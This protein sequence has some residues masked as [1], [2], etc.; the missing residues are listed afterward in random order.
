MSNVH[1]F[2]TAPPVGA[3]QANA[4]IPQPVKP[5][6]L[7]QGLD[8]ATPVLFLPV[9]IETRFMDSAGRSELWVRIYPDQIAINSH[10]PE[11]TSQEIT[12]GQNYWD[13]VWRAGKPPP[14]LDAVKAPW[15]GLASIYGAQ[16]A[17]WIAL[18]M[19]PTN[20]A[21][22]PAAPTPD[23]DNPNPAPAYPPSPATL[24]PSSWTKPAIA[25]ALPDAWTVVTVSGTQTT[26]FKGSPITPDLA[27][28][29]TPGGGQFAP[30]SPVDPGMTWLVDF[31]AALAAGMALK[32]P[33]NPEQRRSGFDRIFVYGLRTSG[34]SGSDAFASLLDAHHYTDGFS[35]VPQGAPTNNTPDAS[36]AYSRKDADYE[37][38]F[39]VERQDALTK[40]ADGDG[41]AFAKG[42]GI[43]PAHMDH[44]G[45]ADGDG[46]CN[47][48]DMLTALWPATLGYFFKQM[49]ADVFTPADIEEIRDFVLANAI[50]RG[51]IPAFR[52]GRTPYGIV[53][54][55]SFSRYQP[56]SVF[57][58][59]SIEPS[60]VNFVRALWPSWLASSGAAPHMQNTGD[61]DKELASVLGMDAS[62]MTFRGRKILGD[63][64]LWNY[65]IFI[66]IPFAS[67]SLWWN[68]HLARGRQLL[69]S[70]GLNRWDPRVIHLGM[71]GDSYPVWFSTVQSGPLSETDPLKADASLSGGT[72]GNYIQWLRQASIGEI[73]SENY[74]GPKPTSLLYKIL[75]QSVILE[76]ARLATFAEVDAGRLQLSQVREAELIAIQPPPALPPVSAWEILARPSIPNPQLNWADYLVLLNPLPSSPFARLAELRASLDRLA[77][78]PTAELDRLLTES[79][80]ACS[81]RLDVWATAVANAMLKRTRDDKVAGVH[82]GAF[83]WV[84]EVRPAAQR[85]PIQ[86]PE[87]ERVRAL[88][89]SRAQSLKTSAALATPVEPLTDNGGFIYAPSLAQASTA[90]VLRNGYMTHKGTADEGILSIDLSS[91]RVR[92]ALMLLDGVSQGQSL[93]ALLGYIFEGEMHD[94]QLD[95][96]I[97]PFRDRFPIWANKLTPSNETAE[98]VAATDVVDG[99]A[100]SAAWQAGN[101]AAGQ[102]W[103]GG[104]PGAGADQNKIV[105]LLQTID[106]YADALSDLSISEA[107]FQIIR[108]NF[109]RA[110]GLMNSISRGERPPHPDIVNTP[111]GGLDLT[112]RV[113]LLFAGSPSPSPAWNGLTKRPRAQAEPWLDAWLG[114]LLPNPTLVRCEVSYHDASG[115][116]VVAIRLADLDLGPLDCLAMADAADVPQQSELEDRIRLATLPPSDATNIHIDF[117]P[118]SP[119]AGTFS[120]PDFF[121][122]VKTLRSA[123]GSARALAPQDLTVPE[124]K[125]ADLGGVD[126]LPDLVARANKAVQ[127]LTADLTALT[128][129]AAGLPGAPGPVRDA[130]LRCSFYGVPGSL[131]AVGTGTDASL[132]DQATAVA[133]TLQD[134]LTQTTAVTL[135]TAALTDVLGVFATIFGDLVVLPRFT[136]PDTTSLQGAFAQSSALVASDTQAPARWLMQLTHIRPALSRLDAA[137]SLAQV[138]GG[139]TV[140]APNLLLGQLPL[141]ANDKW[142][143]LGIDPANPPDKGRVA[144]ACLTQGDPLTQNS[145][146]GLLI[147]EWPERIPSTQETAAVA[148]HYE[149]PKARAPQALLLGV[150]PDARAT[151]DDDLVLGILQETLE[152]SK[153]RTVDLNSVQQ[154]GQILP[155]LYFPFNLKSATISM[156][157]VAKEMI[158]A[159]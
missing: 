44:V 39:A 41:N 122:L 9:N 95:Q 147:D 101:L 68:E 70:F 35:L 30:G 78:L 55:T 127:N 7:P 21:Q 115:D 90:A 150:C 144:F 157:L 10:E 50:P 5:I 29:L 36:S 24:P 81:H 76:H 25:A 100:L 12:D 129:A 134:R 64:F 128:T 74:P 57:V 88:D 123:I 28:G 77:L 43:D 93:S 105:G 130:L 102:N 1:P 22:Q 103:G 106:D 133:K 84:E 20:L 139:S 63:D 140:P 47:G 38:S 118:A 143:G 37:I 86:G 141:A 116:H 79:L 17:A 92:K 26:T 45:Y 153:I 96:Y 145:Y 62:S 71:A 72:K 104:L 131:P 85:R 27:V 110:G 119:P 125:A 149:E 15:R 146:A 83:G 3:V 14:T 114:A 33:L 159:L 58:R 32:I 65:M 94:Q 13:I 138:L 148:F 59:R 56:A 91:E 16:R 152:L 75:R 82:L 126:D 87:H 99:V 73:Q 42:I 112:H 111:R 34:P 49:M 51:P 89:A 136:P 121:F 66:N 67:I 11:L 97:Q 4:A 46:V 8:A 48:T 18:Q 132:A 124:K 54:A 142:L 52:V 98:S 155:A 156:E 80:D 60:V 23:G 69:D 135:A 109:G 2:G 151:W 117:Q 61:P 19:Q 107:V 53:P 113:L 108:G 158:R 6:P 120:F 31:D 40:D 137:T 154:V